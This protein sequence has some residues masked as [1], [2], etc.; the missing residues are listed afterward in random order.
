[1][2]VLVPFNGSNPHSIVVIDNASIYRIDKV[3]QLISGIGSLLWFLPPYNLDLN[4]TEPVFSP[5]KSC[6]KSNSVAYRICD[7]PRLFVCAAFSSVAQEQ[8]L[9]HL[10]MQVINYS[11]HTWM[12]SLFLFDVSFASLCST[13]LFGFNWCTT[14]LIIDGKL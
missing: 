13:W 10:S 5:V 9:G 6:L 11:S 7:N 12:W 3:L 4:S 1:M 2:P 14:P 8:C